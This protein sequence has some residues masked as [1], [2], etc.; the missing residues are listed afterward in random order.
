[1][2][3]GGGPAIPPLGLRV[4]RLRK[5]DGAA[6]GPPSLLHGVGEKHRRK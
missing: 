1:V 6:P 5:S 3:T 2:L 4:R